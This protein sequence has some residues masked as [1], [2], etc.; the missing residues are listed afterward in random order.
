M[1]ARISL[2]YRLSMEAPFKALLDVK[3]DVDFTQRRDELVVRTWSESGGTTYESVVETD[4]NQKAINRAKVKVLEEMVNRV[5]GITNGFLS[6][7]QEFVKSL[8]N[9]EKEK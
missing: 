1:I 9:E 2:R 8:D 3:E 7:A 5:G 4:N 6:G